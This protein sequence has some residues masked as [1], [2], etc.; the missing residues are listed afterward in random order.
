MKSKETNTQNTQKKDKKYIAG[1]NVP[2][3]R[4]AVTTVV[5]AILIALL[6]FAVAVFSAKPYEVKDG[7]V[8]VY[9]VTSTIYSRAIVAAM[10][11]TISGYDNGE[12]VK[13][14]IEVNDDYNSKTDDPIE[15]YRVYYYNKDGKK[16]VASNGIYR[17]NT[18]TMYPLI[19]FFI[20]GMNSLK[21]LQK[22]IIA[23]FV[24][25]IVICVALAGY[26]IYLIVS[27]K[28]DKDY[29]KKLN[30]NNT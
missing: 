2:V 23:V 13:F 24:V 1:T 8:D 20:A 22:V 26:F 14:Y 10:P 12:E 4:V 17:G 9:K 11:K 21:V 30:T 29:H 25:L 27:V 5:L 6:A 3:S 28:K 7:Q 19:G 18:E 16:L 15:Q